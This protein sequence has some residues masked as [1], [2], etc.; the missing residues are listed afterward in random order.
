MKIFIKSLSGKILFSLDVNTSDNI[1]SVKEKIAKKEGIIPD[2]QRLIFLGKILEDNLTL[3]HYNIQNESTLTLILRLVSYKGDN[4]DNED[5]EDDEDDEDKED[6][7][8]KENKENKFIVKDLKGKTYSIDAKPS[9]SIKIV[10]E[11]IHKIKGLPPINQKLLYA[12]KEL[13][14]NLTLSNYNIPKG[15]TIDLMFQFSLLT[16]ITS[17]TDNNE[18]LLK[19]RINTLENEL[20]EEKNKNK[21]LEEKIKSLNKELDEKTN[22]IKN[23]KKNNETKNASS[24]EELYN[25]II[26]KDKE[27]KNLKIILSRYPF[28]LK[29]GEKLMTVNFMSV[30][31]NIQHF[32]LICKNTDIFNFIE[33]KVYDEYK[34]YYNSE[35]YFTVNGKKVNKY[36]NLEENEIHNNDVVILNILDI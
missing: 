23:L 19:K 3:S 14:D 28:E 20:K 2:G 27:I 33:K 32:S 17:K 1:K 10:K 24:K 25:I 18:E 7:E 30:D 8:E 29:D 12:G 9:D 22:I 6:K 26:E 31:N 15:A 11:K 36:K 4:E 13:E 21:I 34:V 16:K 5:N 35:N